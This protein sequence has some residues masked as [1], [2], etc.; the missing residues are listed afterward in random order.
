MNGALFAEDRSRVAVMAYATLAGS[1]LIVLAALPVAMHAPW[2]QMSALQWALLLWASLV[3]AFL[4]WLVWGD[5][6]NALAFAGIGLL[7]AAGLFML[8]HGR[9]KSQPEA[10][11]AASG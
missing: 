7:A 10:L 1:P 3:S 11:D 2:A 5:V 9:G 6:P 4:G 8:T